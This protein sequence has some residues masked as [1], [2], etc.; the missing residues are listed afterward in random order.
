[1]RASLNGPLS[2]RLSNAEVSFAHSEQLAKGRFRRATIFGTHG[3]DGTQTAVTDHQ[4]HAPGGEPLEEDELRAVGRRIRALRK[5][6]GLSLKE[7]SEKA[8]LSTGFLSL[9]ERGR[10]SITLTTLSNVARALDTDLAGLFAPA[11]QD[12]R[13]ETL[14]Y[15]SRARED[16]PGDRLPVIA[17]ILSKDRGYKM[18]SPRASDLALEPILVEVQPNSG[19]YGPFTHEGEEFAFVLSGE[20][21]YIVDGEQ[22]RLGP[23]DSIHVRSTV[24]HAIR[25]DTEYPVRVLWVL[26]P[27]LF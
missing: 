24:R 17:A 2:T 4:S 22:Y 8:G 25:N 11:R 1:M 23:G 6:R 9:F 19:E 3:K 14:P 26:T 13:T 15:V 10:S 16:G 18:L 7:M 12:K 21:V 5:E 27:R 20:M